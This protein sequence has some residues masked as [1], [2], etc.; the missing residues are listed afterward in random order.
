MMLSLRQFV[1]GIDSIASFQ[2][3]TFWTKWKYR[4]QKGL[5]KDV[6]LEDSKSDTKK[7]ALTYCMQQ[8]RNNIYHLSVHLPCHTFAF[9]NLSFRLGI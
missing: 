9:V 1:L 8:I 2:G 3:A 5:R 6:N 4:K 7:N